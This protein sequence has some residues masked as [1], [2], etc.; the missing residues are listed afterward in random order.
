MQTAGLKLYIGA[1]YLM[2]ALSLHCKGI[3]HFNFNNPSLESLSFASG[4]YY[5]QMTSCTENIPQNVDHLLQLCHPSPST[6][7]HPGQRMGWNSFTY[8]IRIIPKRLTR[9][10]S[11]TKIPIEYIFGTLDDLRWLARPLRWK[12]LQM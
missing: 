2:A 4:R 6:P 3:F 7:P 11:W 9:N 12:Y 10:T 8:S 1:L 5:L